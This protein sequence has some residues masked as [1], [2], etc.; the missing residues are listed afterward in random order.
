MS[1]SCITK[2]TVFVTCYIIVDGYST[3]REAGR[4]LGYIWNSYR[5]LG[6]QHKVSIKQVYGI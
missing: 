6:V 5:F 3:T 1:I 2:I 4:F